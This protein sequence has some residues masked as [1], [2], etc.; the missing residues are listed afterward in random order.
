MKC[1]SRRPEIPRSRRC[2]KM[3]SKRTDV[4]AAL[5]PL[6][7]QVLAAPRQVWLH[8]STGFKI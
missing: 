4:L 3:A 2:E 6:M 5:L 7:K 8:R 1:L